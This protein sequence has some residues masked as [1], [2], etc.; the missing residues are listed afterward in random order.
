MKI[1]FCWTGISG[2]MAACWRELSRR[3][4]VDLFVLAVGSQEAE[5]VPFDSTATMEGIPHRLLT[6]KELNDAKMIREIVR[7]QAPDAVVL[8][9]WNVRGYKRLPF[10]PALVD[11]RFALSMDNQR[12]YNLCQ[13][14][15]KV[16]LRRFLKRIELLFVPGERSWQ[17]AKYFGVDEAR[18]IRGCAFGH[19]HDQFSPL[20][21]E[22]SA[23][24][25]GWPRQFLYIGRYIATKG[26]PDLLTAYTSYRK[27]VD[28]PWPLA[29][30]GM[31]PLAGEIEATLGV[32]NLGFVQPDAIREVLLSS[33]AL[34][35]PSR[36][37]PWGLV[38]QEGSAAGLPVIVTDVCGAGTELVR[39]LSNGLIIPTANP[40]ALSEAMLWMHHNHAVLVDMGHRAIGMAAPYAAKN[41]ADRVVA[42]LSKTTGAG[43]A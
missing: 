36:R 12:R 7:Q 41:W 20:W 19:D 17:L 22:R 24:P 29:C 1:V 11:A 35:L 34:I 16:I 9:G 28:D 4:G 6:W 40:A 18:I 43:S 5:N 42:A 13:A 25:S 39:P 15:G 14:A 32:K 33:G 3:P 37:E 30:C 2:Y 26:I 23:S 8:S 21:Q 10:A 38:I 27:A 31:G